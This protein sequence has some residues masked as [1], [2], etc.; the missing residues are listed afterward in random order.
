MDHVF[1]VTQKK[2][3]LA[4]ALMGAVAVAWADEFLAT[5]GV[6]E[7]TSLVDRFTGVPSAVNKFKLALT[8]SRDDYE[9]R[10]FSLITSA[11]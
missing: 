4:L 6:K 10:S 1:L 5:L 11:A 3:A 8:G 7:G 9:A 2:L